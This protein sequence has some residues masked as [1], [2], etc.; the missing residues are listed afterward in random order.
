MQSL[1]K[2]FIS[3]LIFLTISYAASGLD[4]IKYEQSYGGK[5]AGKGG[6]GKN[7]NV[8]FDQ[9]GN[10]YIS[11][12]GNKIVQKLSPQG[13]FIMQ[14]PEEERTEPLFKK[15]GD[16]CVDRNGNI[17]VADYTAHHIKKTENPK[18]Y[19]FAPCVYKFSQKGELL[20]TYFIDPV[21]VFPKIKT[22][23]TARLMIDE[24]GKSAFG[25]QPEGFDRKLLVDVD[26]ND[27]IYI[28]DVKN[29]VVHKLDR[30]GEELLKFGRYGSG[31]GEFD[32]AADIEIDTDSN[33]WVADKGNHRIVKFSS[34]GMFLFAVGK[35]GRGN[36]EFVKP[37]EISTTANGKVLVKDETQFVRDLLEHPFYVSDDA[38]SGDF[39]RNME[40]S[41]RAQ[42]SRSSDQ[43]NLEDLNAR[44]RYLEDDYYSLDKDGEDKDEA[45]TDRKIQ[46]IKNTIYSN[47]IE[48]IQIFNTEGKYLTRAIYQIDKISP[49][50]HDLDFLA[51][52]QFGHVYLLD[53]DELTIRQ[54]SIGGFTVRPSY[55]NGVYSTRAENSS[56][57]FS[58]DYSDINEEPDLD[59]DEGIFRNAHWLMLNYDL[60]ERWNF[61][62][63][64]TTEYLE[65][66]SK[67]ITPPRLEDSYGADRQGISNSFGTRLRFVTN[68]NIYKYKELNL[69]LQRSDGTADYGSDALYKNVNL[70]ES[71]QEGDASGLRVGFDWDMFTNTNLSFEYLDQNPDITSHNWTREYYDVSGDLYE[72]FSS[73]NRSRRFIGEL[74]IA[75]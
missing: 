52:D 37:I 47:V 40:L 6:F 32:D 64:N 48:R 20:K 75:F 22:A 12:E 57:N 25:I 4:F 59:Q 18:I 53:K 30:D 9:G 14:I 67:Y 60:S 7:I 69:Y 2:L 58:E 17:Y 68:P 5:G 39:Y 44:L 72:V 16:I 54:Y 46:R 62:L 28:L 35:K 36:G 10:I 49:E 8:A 24:E 61:N 26:G 29:C 51:L 31:N 21:D 55:M 74:R 13:D 34:Q 19:F 1:H 71:Q 66:D 41:S 27:N 73:G 45:E 38:V 3:L 65:Y 50:H 42:P 33:I 56:N 70:E 43:V 15:P 11:D 63:E 23:L